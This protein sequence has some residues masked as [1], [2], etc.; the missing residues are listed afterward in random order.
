[1]GKTFDRKSCAVGVPVIIPSGYSVSVVRVDYRGYSNVPQ[2]GRG[3]FSTEY[4][5]AGER[6]PRLTENFYGGER[7]Y[8]LTDNVMLRGLSWSRCGSQENLRINTGLSLSTNRRGDDAMITLDSIDVDSE[9][10]FHL[11]WRRCN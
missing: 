5:F 2:G 10:V 11:Q 7:N 8:T 3:Q 4:F 1:M 9:V 6:S